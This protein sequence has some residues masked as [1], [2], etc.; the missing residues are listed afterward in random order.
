MGKEPTAP[1]PHS[2]SRTPSE[3]RP[4]SRRPPP[5]ASP[6]PTPREK[7]GSLP[8]CPIP[9]PRSRPRPC[10]PQPVP[11]YCP[12]NEH[13]VS[14]NET[15]QE[16]WDGLTLE[17]DAAEYEVLSA[18]QTGWGADF[19]GIFLE[20]YGLGG[21]ETVVDAGCGTGRVTELL[22]RHLPRGTVLAV[23]ASEAMVEASR[24]RFAGDG[25]VRVERSDILRLEVD[26]PVDV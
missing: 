14:H 13:C 10:S 25:R 4:P 17:W 2:E 1:L 3:Y 18:S 12:Y 19:L 6:I 23:D 9:R 16:G 15:K 20:R 24:R 21:D 22:L 11:L 7:R 26:E 8:P 5:P